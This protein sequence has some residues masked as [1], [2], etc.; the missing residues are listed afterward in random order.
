MQYVVFLV[1]WKFESAINK[2]WGGFAD[3]L[4][5]PSSNKSWDEKAPKDLI[6]VAVP[7]VLLHRHHRQRKDKLSEVFEACWCSCAL[8][9][10]VGKTDDCFQ[11]TGFGSGISFSRLSAGACC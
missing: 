3:F 2:H 10:R 1:P 8:G 4:K 9:V 11:W 5:F 7:D 6:N